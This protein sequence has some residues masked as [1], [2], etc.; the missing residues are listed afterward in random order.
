MAHHNSEIKAEGITES[1]TVS[2]IMDPKALHAQVT[3]WHE[4]PPSWK[5]TTPHR[6]TLSE[7]FCLFVNTY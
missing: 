3:L 7:D 4:K 5:Y 1:D 2:D 6:K